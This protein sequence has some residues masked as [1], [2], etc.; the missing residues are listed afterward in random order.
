V[1]GPRRRSFLAALFLAAAWVARGLADVPP[2]ATVTI[3]HFNDVYEID[4]VEDGRA[5]GLARVA[6]SLARLKRSGPV[7]STLGGD[8]LSPSALGTARVNGEPLAG[9]QMVGVLNTLGLN[10]ATL[11]NHEFDL[12]EAAFRARLAE[13]TFRIVASNVT[14]AA[15]QPFPGT[16]K[17][18]VVPV[19]ANGRTLRLGLIGLTIDSTRKPWV[20]YQ[21][22]VEAARAQVASLRGRTDATIALTHLS[23]AGDQA[24]VEGVPE[25]DVALGGHEHENW[26]IR[27]GPAFTPIVK[28]DANVRS[29]AL[30]SLGFRKPGE[31][32]TV[33]AR[34]EVLDAKVA[35]DRRVQAEVQRWITTA[36]DAFRKDGFAPE[37]VIAK[38]T[39]VLDGRESTV[40]NRPGP[41]T[42]LI[43]AAMARETGSVDVVLLNGGSI[44]IDDEL[45][46]GPIRQ[47]DVIR[48][49]PFGGKIVKATFEGS[50]LAEVLDIGVTNRGSGGYLHMRGAARPDT[51][52]LIQ[53]KPIDRSARYSVAVPEFLLTGGEANLKFLT[54]TEPRVS[55]IQELR[56]VRLAVIDELKAR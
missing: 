33:S 47:Y 37:T 16:V 19:V 17:S 44:R 36:F 42:D 3:L 31:R 21:D 46:P 48:I 10:W 55:S 52:W 32:P 51:T 45:Q 27:R 34:L 49:L 26:M 35:Q 8:F 15:G 30:V 39:T 7:L 23:L 29:I 6:T 41:L 24:L 28:A 20:Q 40:R 14:D 43:T 25:I 5:G 1:T 56:D 22:P 54:R 9:R 13:A 11:G 50:L 18:A 2:P 12:S 53:G 38:T 4:A